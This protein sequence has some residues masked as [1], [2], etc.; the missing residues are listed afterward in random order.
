MLPLRSKSFRISSSQSNVSN[1]SD[2]KDKISEILQSLKAKNQYRTLTKISSQGPT[3]SID[4][5]SYVSFASNDYLGLSIDREIIQQSQR[6]FQ[7]YG[8]G[9][10]SSRLVSGNH[11]L[12]EELES[13]IATFKNSEGCL[14]FGSGYLANLGVIQSLMGSDDLILLDRLSHNSLFSAA[15]L[16]KSTL[17]IFEHN[18]LTSLS[19]RLE[20]YRKNYRNCLVVTESVFSMDGDLSPYNHLQEIC[21]QHNATLMIDDA[22]GL[23]VI[24]NGKGVSFGHALPSNIILTGTLSKAIG[25]YGGYVCA[26]TSVIDLLTNKANTLIY[27]TSLP[28]F[29]IAAA[30]LSLKK[31]RENGEIVK[32]LSEK[33]DLFQ[34]S[35]GIDL[36]SAIFPFKFNDEQDAINASDHLKKFGFFV[37]AIRPPTVPKNGSRLRFS[38]SAIHDEHSLKR[39]AEVLLDYVS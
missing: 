4:G 2:F 30:N 21:S 13:S 27:S 1:S 37:P 6:I 9:S 20:K 8:I 35:I 28:P 10:G 33:I 11:D 14:V 12:Y 26:N 24:N 17:K 31:I 38:L 36:D 16:T 5:K 34:Q 3:V 22:H 39:C 15:K 29:V 25:S 32:T 19:N 23:G 7:D 18:S